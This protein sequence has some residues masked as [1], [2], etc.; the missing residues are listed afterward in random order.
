VYFIFL[1]VKKSYGFFK[2]HVIF[3]KKVL[4]IAIYIQSFYVNIVPSLHILQ[5]F[6]PTTLLNFPLAPSIAPLGS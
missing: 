3:E 1:D 4:K 6:S 2:L 5:F